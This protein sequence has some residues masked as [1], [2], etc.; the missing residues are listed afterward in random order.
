[1][2]QWIA[3]AAASMSMA[4]CGHRSAV[5]GLAHTAVHDMEALRGKHP[6]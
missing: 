4:D 5:H 3:S 2:G 1:M 6:L